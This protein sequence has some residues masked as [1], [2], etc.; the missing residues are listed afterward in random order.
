MEASSCELKRSRAVLL[1]IRTQYI[2]EHIA[3][4]NHKSLKTSLKLNN[5]CR[6]WSNISITT[7]WLLGKEYGS[8]L[9]GLQSRPGTL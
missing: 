3:W 9:A 2:W 4:L 7:S 8:K 5:M 1:V 6:F